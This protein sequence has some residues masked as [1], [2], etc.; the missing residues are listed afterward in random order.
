MSQTE[1]NELY[2][3]RAR[4]A[5]YESDIAE[6]KLHVRVDGW[7]WWL[8]SHLE[9]TAKRWR[10]EIQAEIDEMENNNE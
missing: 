10:L 2:E 8:L 3:L 4:Y 1:K 5:S 6:L 7:L 9:S